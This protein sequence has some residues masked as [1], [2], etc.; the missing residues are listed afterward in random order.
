MTHDIKGK[1]AFWWPFKGK[2][3]SATHANLIQI[4]ST[5]VVNF[6]SN[7]VETF[8]H[9]CA[10]IGMEFFIAKYIMCKYDL[11]I[12]DTRPRILLLLWYWVVIIK[13]TKKNDINEFYPKLSYLSNSI[14]AIKMV[15]NII[16]NFALILAHW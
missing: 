7:D 3:E 2:A 11:R 5:C 10:L 15:L 16:H 12:F 8:W 1:S 13:R 6:L 14:H 9:L 4:L